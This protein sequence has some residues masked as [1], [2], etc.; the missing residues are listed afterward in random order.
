MEKRT[1]LAFVLSVLVIVVWSALAPKQ[2]PPITQPI[3]NKVVTTINPVSQPTEIKT[4][5]DF[6]AKA[7]AEEIQTDDYAVS[8]LPQ[9]AA[10]REVTFKK[11]HQYKLP[12]KGFFL[13]GI[14]GFSQIQLGPVSTF[15]HTDGEKKITQEYNF[16]NPNYYIGLTVKI[17]NLKNEELK[18]DLPLI[19]SRITRSSGKDA[20]FQ[21]QEVVIATTEKV[22]RFAPSK[23]MFF[24]GPVKF[25]AFRERYFCA[26][27]Q[28]ES[29]QTQVFNK[30]LSAGEN[31]FGMNLGIQI[32]ANK[33]VTL[34]FALYLGPQDATIL[35]AANPKWPEVIN[36][37]FFDPI[38]KFLLQLMRFLF[39]IVHNW[40]VAII[41]LSLL[42][43]FVLF[44]LSLQQLRSMKEMQNLQPKMEALKK[45]Y[46]DNPQR[47]NK[48]I[49]ELYKEHKVN[50]FGGCLPM[51]LQIPVFFALYQA[52]MRSLE[53]K[54][55]SF[56]WIKDLSRP[57]QLF[58][59]P[60]SLP[61]IGNEINILPLLMCAVMFF[62]QKMTS[63]AAVS[64]EQQKMML[65]L[66]PLMFGLI[67]YHM[68][69]GLVIY[70]FINSLLMFVYQLKISK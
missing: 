59:L 13:E 6:L 14:S 9:L 54:G 47:L 50:P 55:A 19:L 68:P 25:I 51:L 52:L 61:V 40:G 45:M 53:L 56:L 35:S 64:S 63:K 39:K 20:Q 33:E 1:L 66:F 17:K 10:V 2:R 31:E 5:D 32:P 70:W 46:K 65:I 23:E 67:F 37:G 12:L 3:E 22:S 49:M 18:L 29:S 38:S 69:S 44:P 11:Y 57:D 15:V 62:Q 58:T 36:Y 7:P 26:I 34:K 43:Y 8:L 28:P 30:K 16:S 27:L 41:L 4:T 42:I 48:E 60:N 24:T 21:S